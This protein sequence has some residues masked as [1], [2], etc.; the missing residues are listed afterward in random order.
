MTNII[1]SE[2]LRDFIGYETEMIGKICDFC[3]EMLP[4]EFQSTKCSK[5]PTIFDECLKCRVRPDSS[6]CH[7][8]HNNDNKI[9]TDKELKSIISAIPTIKIFGLTYKQRQ[10]LRY[11]DDECFIS[12]EC[13]CLN[14]DSS[15]PFRRRELTQA[16]DMIDNGYQ[17]I[18][19]GYDD[20]IIMEIKF[21]FIYKN[22]HCKIYENKSFIKIDHLDETFCKQNEIKKIDDW[23]VS[24][25]FSNDT[26]ALKALYII[27]DNIG[28]QYALDSEKYKDCEKEFT[29]L[30]LKD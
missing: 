30:K 2:N 18:L 28:Q 12:D 26:E 21:P 17:F 9:P 19:K 5:C 7:K 23:Y 6:I 4:K 15:E 27:I 25:E 11:N 10:K 1:I 13:E 24:K 22:I 8:T 29:L 20:C 14:L 16:A 3:G